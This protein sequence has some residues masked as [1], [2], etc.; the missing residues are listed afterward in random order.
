DSL[1][2]IALFATASHPPYVLANGSVAVDGSLAFFTAAGSSAW[3]E[4]TTFELGN[5]IPRMTCSTVAGASA[6]AATGP[7]DAGL[8]VCPPP[9]GACAMSAAVAM[10]NDPA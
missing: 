7:R 3:A 8:A 1:S 6:G 2:A 10:A 5:R 4:N 9:A